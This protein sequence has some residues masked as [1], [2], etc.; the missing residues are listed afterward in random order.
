VHTL[1]VLDAN[2]ILHRLGHAF[3]I[4]TTRADSSGLSH[5][6]AGMPTFEAARGLAQGDTRRTYGPMAA[7]GLFMPTRNASPAAGA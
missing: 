7:D 1:G 5:T 4:H 3:S 6:F 2:S